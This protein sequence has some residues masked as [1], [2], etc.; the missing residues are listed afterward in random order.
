MK[1][2]FFGVAPLLQV[3]DMPAAVRFYRDVLGFQLVNQSSEGEDFDWCSLSRNGAEIM[4]NTMYE[5]EHRPPQPE[6]KRTAAHHDTGLF[7]ACRDLD[8][9]YE[10][11]RSEGV[12]LQSPRV[13]SYGMR[14]LWFRDPDGYGI[15]FQWPADDRWAEQWRHRYG[16]K[17]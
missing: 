14:Q 4:L 16:F 12:D 3:F 15:C 7:F 2:D 13:A 1:P 11:L 5:R 10:H 6:A 8:S 17:V 9:A